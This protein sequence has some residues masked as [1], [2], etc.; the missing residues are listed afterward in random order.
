MTLKTQQSLMYPQDLK[1]GPNVHFHATPAKAHEVLVRLLDL[2]SLPVRLHAWAT[3]ADSCCL[4]GQPFF[5]DGPL[6]R[7]TVQ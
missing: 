4:M 5:F 7:N 3:L 1:L 2:S 6:H